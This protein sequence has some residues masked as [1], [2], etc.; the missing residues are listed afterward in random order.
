MTEANEEVSEFV[1]VQTFVVLLLFIFGF[2]EVKTTKVFRETGR[3]PE[4]VYVMY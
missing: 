3:L 1:S 2:F 4:F